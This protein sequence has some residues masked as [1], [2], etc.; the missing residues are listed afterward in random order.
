MQ[1]TISNIVEVTKV[2]VNQL[3]AIILPITQSTVCNVIYIVDDMRSKTVKGKK[4]VQKMS[5]I[6]H[7]YLNHDY[8]NKVQ[9]LTENGEFQ[10]YEL[11]GKTKIT[12]TILQSNSTK[13]FMLYGTVLK[14]ETAK[15]LSYFHNGNEITEAEAIAMELWTP[16]YYNPTPTK[17]MGRGTVNEE[18][19]FGLISPYLSRIYRIKVMGQWYEVIND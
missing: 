13:E 3:L 19:D 4:Q 18:N 6:T 15:I 17:T 5:Q 9:K 16:T 1:S 10:A 11:N 8:Q 14:K 2:T 12:N 7:C